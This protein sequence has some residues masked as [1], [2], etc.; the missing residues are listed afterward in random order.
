MIGKDLEQRVYA[1]ELVDRKSGLAQSSQISADCQ[2]SFISVAQARFADRYGTERIAETCKCDITSAEHTGKFEEL[3]VPPAIGYI[4]VAH[5][6]FALTT[7]DTPAERNDIE[8]GGAV[9]TYLTDS[10]ARLAAR[11]YGQPG[12]E[13]I[14]VARYSVKVRTSELVSLDTTRDD[15]T[16]VLQ[17]SGCPDFQFRG[18]SQVGQYL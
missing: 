17:E 11:L 1:A 14:D 15:L 4:A 12:I 6:P 3:T 5:V 13:A 18:D 8:F 2:S 7:F 16:V 9:G 10:G